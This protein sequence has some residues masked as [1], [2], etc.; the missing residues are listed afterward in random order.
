MRAIFFDR[1]GVLTIP[2]NRNKKGFAPINLNEFSIYE[3]AKEALQLSH[4]RGY[5]NL[6]ISNQPDV[7]NGHLPIEVL[8]KMDAILRKELTLEDIYYCM[9]AQ[10]ENCKCRKPGIQLI[11]DASYKWGIS[12][13]DSWFIGDRESDIHAGITAGCRTIFIDRNWTDES[14]AKADFEC[15]DVK[16]AVLHIIDSY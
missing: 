5:I 1:D 11:L 3:T 14:G 4:D 15:K 12:L 16:S 13:R 8:N 10:S 9:H 2:I 7:A 6:V